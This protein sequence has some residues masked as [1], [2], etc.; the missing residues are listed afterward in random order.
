MVDVFSKPSSTDSFVQH[1]DY[2][3]V[4]LDGSQCAD[5][6]RWLYELSDTPEYRNLYDGTKWAAMR[7][8]GPLLVKA[9]S[10][11]SLIHALFQKG[12]AFELGYGIHSDEQ[13]DTIADCLRQFLTVR[14]PLGHEVMLRFA[15][16][17]VAR[18]LLASPGDGGLSGYGCVFSAVG[19]PDA[20]WNC[21]HHQ[22]RSEPGAGHQPY[23][24]V[25]SHLGELTLNCLEDVDRRAA[26][27]K[28]VKHLE[29]YF[30]NRAT[31]S[32]RP[33]AIQSLRQLM[34]QALEN[35]YTSLQALTHWGTV[36]GCLGEPAQWKGTFPDI[37]QA[38]SSPDV[39]SAEGQARAAAIAAMEWTQAEHARSA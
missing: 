22:S 25:G 36:Y 26:L 21:W 32:V 12:N 23:D 13:V 20:L 11:P 9:G 27:I 24:M 18:V 16:P 7:Q 30:P 1:C 6:E 2:N 28:L 33:K 15:S 14:H 4:L 5:A 39:D 29:H 8:A 10:V 31:P 38:F 37:Y 17:A 3:Y 19:L 35:G 34:D